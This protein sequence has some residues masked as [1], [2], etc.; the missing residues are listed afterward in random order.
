MK[1]PF[2]R[3][4]ALFLILFFLS[5]EGC[6]KRFV[7]KDYYPLTLGNLYEYSGMLGRNKVTEKIGDEKIQVYT[8]SYLDNLGNVAWTEEYVVEKNQVFKRSFNPFV[9]G[10]TNF[11]FSPPLL[12]SPLSDKVGASKTIQSKEYRANHSQESLRIKVDYLI[13]KIEDV[14][15]QA[16]FF[17][18][19][20]KMK[21]SYFYLD[22][23]DVR[24]M[25]EDSFFWFAKGVEIVKYQTVG[26]AGELIKAKIGEKSYP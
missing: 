12:F 11:S 5:F 20:I 15:V 3:F 2:F 1:N 18:N 8:I 10:F 19:C 14:S 16:G 13:E 24:F 21:M 25:Y 7:G 17:K 22:S 9:K 26:G 6:G 23:T 4:S